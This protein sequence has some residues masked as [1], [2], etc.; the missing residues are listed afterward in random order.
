MLSGPRVISRERL[1]RMNT[2]SVPAFGPLSKIQPRA[3]AKGGKSMGTNMRVYSRRRPGRS[4]R[5][6]SQ[7]KTKASGRDAA[8]A[9]AA[10]SFW[11]TKPLTL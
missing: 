11:L 5:S 6:V 4:V 1:V 8:I 2:F 9:P 7:A 10:Y 3:M